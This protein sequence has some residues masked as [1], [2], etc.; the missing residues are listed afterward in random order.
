[1]GEAEQK[2]PIDLV[3][4]S[5]VVDEKD[6]DLKYIDDEKLQLSDFKKGVLKSLDRYKGK[7][8]ITEKPEV[9]LIPGSDQEEDNPD[10]LSGD[11]SGASG[12]E[13]EENTQP[14]KRSKLEVKKEETESQ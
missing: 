2:G 3:D 5:W 6:S 9:I 11:D 4:S 8:P 14:V 10:E 12:S 13:A 7:D 1:M